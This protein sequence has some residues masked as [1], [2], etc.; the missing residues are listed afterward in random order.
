MKSFII[1]VLLLVVAAG[2]MYWA[3]WI[4]FSNTDKDTNVQ[5]HKETI[6]QDTEKVKDKLKG[7]V[8]KGKDFIKSESSGQ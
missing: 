1:V 8:D 6:K 2:G 4:T 3:G 5:F 7:A